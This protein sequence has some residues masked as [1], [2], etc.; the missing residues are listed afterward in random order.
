M[1]RIKAGVMRAVSLASSELA[2][3]TVCYCVGVGLRCVGTSTTRARRVW[4][5]KRSFWGRGIVE[6][7]CQKGAREKAFRFD[8]E[9][10]HTH[11]FSLPLFSFFPLVFP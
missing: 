5:K 8:P 2:V 1:V 10:W 4:K 7:V 11:S 3:L 6:G 9:S